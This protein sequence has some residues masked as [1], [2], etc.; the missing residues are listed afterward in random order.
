MLRAAA[1]TNVGRCHY[2]N[3]DAFTL[4]DV[5]T[6][7][8]ATEGSLS[9]S[10]RSQAAILGVYDGTGECAPGRSAGHVAAGVVSERL[11]RVPAGATTE[12]LAQRLRDA[13][14]AAHR[15]VFALN[16]TRRRPIAATTAT[17]AAIV[18][19][20]VRIVHIGDS[21]AYL[22]RGGELRQLTRDDTLVQQLLDEGKLKP[23]EI[24]SHPHRTVVTLLL[25]FAEETDVPMTSLAL[26]AGDAF[27][28]CT[29]GICTL[30]DDLGIS[31]I[32]STHLDPAAACRALIEAAEEAGGFH[33][34]TAVVA[35]FEPG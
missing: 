35:L 18:G 3:E 19:H 10:L 30:V 23:E 20:D 33:N 25:G 6:G 4:I 1:L 28:L 27:L 7:E 9:G 11:A 8:S 14:Q 31:G 15:E 21:R 29:P 34:E 24:A 32:M 16:Q 12:A 2:L 22:F 5:A 13:V 26:Q 17:L